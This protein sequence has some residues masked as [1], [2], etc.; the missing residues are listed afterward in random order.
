MIVMY[1][2]VKPSNDTVYVK[3]E[4]VM[5]P[6]IVGVQFGLGHVCCA[7]NCCSVGAVTESDGTVSLPFFGESWPEVADCVKVPWCCPSD[8][9]PPLLMQ[10]TVAVYVALKFAVAFVLPTPASSYELHETLRPLTVQVGV[11]VP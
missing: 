3:L 2:P 4:S 11:G 7:R 6:G 10:T 1:D 5:P 8:G 9:F